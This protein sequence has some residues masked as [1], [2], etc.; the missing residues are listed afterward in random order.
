VAASPAQT[1]DK[2]S[3][4]QPVPNTLA[5]ESNSTRSTLSTVDNVER[6]EIDLTPVCTKPYNTTSWNHTARKL[7]QNVSSKTQ[8]ETDSV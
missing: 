2:L 7:I 3:T 4:L 5:T 6:V 1:V 8:L